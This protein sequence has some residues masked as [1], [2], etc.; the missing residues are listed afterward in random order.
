MADVFLRGNEALFEEVR[1]A[2]PIGRLIETD[3]VAAA[4]VWLCSSAGSG[5]FGQT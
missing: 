2:M 5:V 1:V 3:E 4:A